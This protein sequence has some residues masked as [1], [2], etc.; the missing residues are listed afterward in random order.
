MK[1][2]ACANTKTSRLKGNFCKTFTFAYLLK[3]QKNSEI[4]KPIPA[5]THGLICCIFTRYKETIM[6]IKI[7]GCL[8][9]PCKMATKYVYKIN[10]K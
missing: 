7:E 3:E 8:R 9:K 10:V 2:F 1:T 6:I 5:Q 4:E